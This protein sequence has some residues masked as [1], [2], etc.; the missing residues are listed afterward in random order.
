MCSN[1]FLQS[2]LF[3]S[4]FFNNSHM[5]NSSFFHHLLFLFF[6]PN[7]FHVCSP[8]FF[9]IP[10]FICS[11]GK[12][13]FITETLFIFTRQWIYSFKTGFSTFNASCFVYLINSIVN[14]HGSIEV[15]WCI[16]VAHLFH[17]KD[18][19]ITQAISTIF[20]ASSWDLLYQWLTETLHRYCR[21]M[22]SIKFNGITVQELITIRFFLPML[23]FSHGIKGLNQLIIV[24]SFYLSIE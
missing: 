5:L 23:P 18:I 22:I 4:L 16:Y 7:F 12:L 20:C 24:S 6:D 2:F 14:F 9:H 8:I 11:H 3:Y 10:N 21:I 19:S 17:V 13:M 1:L 15:V